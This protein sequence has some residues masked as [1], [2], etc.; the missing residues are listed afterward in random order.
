MSIELLDSYKSIQNKIYSYVGADMLKVSG[1][2]MI[3]MDHWDIIGCEL[4]FYNVD[5]SHSYIM[6]SVNH[7]Y[8]GTDFNM[9][10]CDGEFDSYDVVVINSKRMVR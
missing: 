3:E 8:Y 6:E 2:L 5:G 10:V 4:H 7:E 9:F 1:N